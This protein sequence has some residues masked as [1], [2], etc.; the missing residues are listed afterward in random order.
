M[1]RKRQL[2]VRIDQELRDKFKK[3]VKQMGLSTCFLIETW[4]KTWL[5]GVERAQINHASKPY[6]ITTKV[7]Y[8]VGKARPRRRNPVGHGKA[9]QFYDAFGNPCNHY[10]PVTGWYYDDSHPETIVVEQ[11]IE[12]GKNRCAV[13]F[14]WNASRKVWW[15]F[16]ER[17]K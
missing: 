7:N 6:T 4:I 11:P 3:T 15:K 10:D 2:N 8:K 13:D 12:W 14:T 5:D 16:I 9:S 1:A 17:G